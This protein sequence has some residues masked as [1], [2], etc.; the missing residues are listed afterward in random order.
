MVLGSTDRP[1]MA[2]SPCSTH[3]SRLVTRAA[4]AG[5]RAVLYA[6]EPDDR[7][8]GALTET[9]CSPRPPAHH[10]TEAVAFGLRAI[11]AGRVSQSA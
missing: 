4:K 10:A 6:P 5:Q 7:R 1:S 8:A 11:S 2:A 9:Q 3:P